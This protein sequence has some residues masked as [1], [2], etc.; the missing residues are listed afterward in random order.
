[1]KELTD[2]QIDL[3]YL[4]GVFNM[5]GLDGLGK[6]IERLKNIGVTPHEMI[7]DLLRPRDGITCSMVNTANTKK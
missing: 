1:M 3:I 4:L 6:E 2:N 5:T 7:N